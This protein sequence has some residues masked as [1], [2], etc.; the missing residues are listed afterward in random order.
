MPHPPYI[1]RDRVSAG[2]LTALRSNAPQL[3]ADILGPLCLAAE[4]NTPRRIAGLLAN[5]LHETGGHRF[6]VERLSYAATRLTEVWPSRFPGLTDARPFACNPEALANHVYGGR[7]GNL[8]P[9]DGWRYIGRGLLQVTGRDNYARLALAT[10]RPIE[11]LP[12]WMETHQGAAESAVRWWSWRGCNAI[13]DA[14][15]IEALRRAVNGGA[16]GLDDVRA[17]YEAALQILEAAP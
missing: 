17:R 4:I 3:W 7:L 1:S 9:G 11:E 10:G 12:A 13:A 14:G 2:L 16:I 8:N 5:T 6:V 15:D